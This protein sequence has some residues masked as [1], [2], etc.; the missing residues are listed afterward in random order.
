MRLGPSLLSANGT[1]EAN[2]VSVDFDLHLPPLPRH[3]VGVFA[4]GHR[5]TDSTRR[6]VKTEGAGLVVVPVGLDS[7]V[8]PS[9][10]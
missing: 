4:R 3:P 9:R 5:G 7:H 10:V 1:T 2:H 6:K 8:T